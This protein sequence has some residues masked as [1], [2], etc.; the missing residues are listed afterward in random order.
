MSPCLSKAFLFKGNRTHSYKHC[1]RATGERIKG[2]CLDYAKI[3]VSVQKYTLTKCNLA[4]E[5]SLNT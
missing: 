4:K 3:N 1:I 5:K 2:M